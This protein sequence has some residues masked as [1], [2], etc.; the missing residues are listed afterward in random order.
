MFFCCRDISLRI[1]AIRETFEEL[2]V[3]ICKNKEQLKDSNLL[4]NLVHNFD[5]AFWQKQVR[6]AHFVVKFHIRMNYL[7]TLL[8]ITGLQGRIELFEIV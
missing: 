1:T 8:L 4:S 5:V 3:L 7:I 2:G 6:F